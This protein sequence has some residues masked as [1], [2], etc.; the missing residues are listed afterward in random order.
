MHV[1][2]RI[3]E[4]QCRLNKRDARRKVDEIRGLATIEQFSTKD[5][6]F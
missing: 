3:F 6:N 2:R 5:L 4:D 1:M